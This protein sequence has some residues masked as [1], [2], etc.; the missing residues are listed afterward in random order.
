MTTRKQFSSFN[1]LITNTSRPVLV[2]FYA[3]W[4]GYCQSFAPILDRVKAKIGDRIQVVKINS[5]KYPELASQYEVKSLPTTLL[6]TEGE[7]A[8]RIKGMMQEGE[9]LQYLQKFL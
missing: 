1:D 5:E 9:L 6:F 4:C 7:L 3:T 8:S 2:S